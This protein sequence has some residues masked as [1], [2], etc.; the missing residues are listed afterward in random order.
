[1]KV[2]PTESPHQKQRVKILS[3]ILNSFHF[4]S[5]DAT[6]KGLVHLLSKAFKVTLT[7]PF[8]TFLVS[9]AQASATQIVDSLLRKV[10]L[11]QDDDELDV[12]LYVPILKI[13]LLYP[14]RLNSNIS[15]LF[16]QV[17]VGCFALCFY[18]ESKCKEPSFTA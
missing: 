2:K 4:A 17:A 15:T 6:K 14:E 9:S 7:D 3:A 10:R 11:Q 8:S 5:S 12:A 18:R 1:L 13:L 16:V